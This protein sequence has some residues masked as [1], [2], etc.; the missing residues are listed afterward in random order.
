MAQVRRG[1]VV[2]FRRIFILFCTLVL[3]PSV[4]LSGFGV[5]AILNER[6]ADDARRQKAAEQ[7]LRTAKGVLLRVLERENERVSEN[8]ALVDDDGKVLEGDIE[9]PEPIAAAGRPLAL[10]QTVFVSRPSGLL[11][12]SREPAGT[13]AAR[14]DDEALRSRL[15][16]LIRTDDE[17]HIALRVSKVEAPEVGVVDRLM[18]KISDEDTDVIQARAAVEPPFERYELVITSTGGAAT[19]A[20]VIYIVLLSLFYALLIPGVIL[21]S[22]LIWKETRLSRLKTDFVSHVSHELRT[23]LTSIRMFIETLQMGRAE[24]IE[25]QEECLALLSKETERLSDMIERVLGYAR[26]RAGRR[27]FECE[28]A[29]VRKLVDDAVGA[30]RAQSIGDD[31]FELVVDVGDD[32]P[33]VLVDPESVV[34]ALLNLIVNAH[35]YAAEA[36]YIRVYAE[37]R[38]GR[39]VSL[40]V[41]DRGPGLE[42]REHKRIFERFY[43]AGQLLSSSSKGSG[44]GLAITKAII[45][46]QDGK[47]RVE[48]ERGRGATFILELPIAADGF[49]ESA[50]SEK[51][52]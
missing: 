17:L 27:P 50:Q 37:Q 8:K 18:R 11:I 35:K 48:S 9:A 5:I 25:E 26:L 46:G 34:E 33:A 47:V 19:T 22:R 38:G 39:R 3:L 36:R 43:Q 20:T 30:F 49:N 6:G 21:T 7:L 12:L 31:G 29:S 41:E 42:K 32:L 45:E 24:S 16:A 23:P 52:A 15:D 10:G 14:I 13:R 28:P 2:G 1:D 44:L 40:A 4:L 51:V